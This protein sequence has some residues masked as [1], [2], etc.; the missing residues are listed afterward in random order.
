MLTFSRNLAGMR[1][2]GGGGGL[3]ILGEGPANKNQ[4]QDPIPESQPHA[5]S[6]DR[7]FWRDGT[8]EHGG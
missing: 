8:S 7:D 6:Q 2:A 4:T 5:C 1:T 3:A